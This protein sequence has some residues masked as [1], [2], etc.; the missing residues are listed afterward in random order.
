M[1][2]R[3]KDRLKRA[4]S[5][6]TEPDLCRELGISTAKF[7]KWRAKFGGIGTLMMSKIKR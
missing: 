4:D 5:G 6:I 7:Y 1:D 3:A 2:S